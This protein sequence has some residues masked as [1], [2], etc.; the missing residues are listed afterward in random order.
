M[1]LATAMTTVDETTEAPCR[2]RA[3]TL[4][5]LLA[6]PDIL[7]PPIAVIPYLAWPS[8]L[9]MIVGR[10]KCGKSTMVGQAVAA[11][12]VGGEFL[13]AHMDPSR[14]LWLA[15]DEPVQDLVQRLNRFGADPDNVLVVEGDVGM[16][17][18]ERVCEDFRPAAIIV[19]CLANLAA[20]T[21]GDPGNAMEWGNI[22][23]PLR[24][25]ARRFNASFILIHH[26]RKA[27]DEF[28]DSTA[29]GAQ[30][31]MI[32][33]VL[34]SK[35]GETRREI[36]VKGRVS[37]RHY[38]VDFRQD[39]YEL[40]SD[41]PAEP[42]TTGDDLRIQVLEVLAGAEPEGLPTTQWLKASGVSPSAFY[43]MRGPFTEQKLIRVEP[44]GNT[45]INHLT[46]AGKEFVAL[47]A[48]AQAE[49]V[50]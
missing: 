43:R 48:P 9:S 32:L 20:G 1:A 40:V 27:S 31:D 36:R 11:L 8:R 28:R 29:I 35:D 3:R 42:I 7:K 33:T 18:L 23:L 34:Q 44:K 16:E 10:E 50:I 38:S 6:D 24:D 49:L 19:D 21:V 22:F 17:D 39:R 15:L 12:S 2:F 46:S 5:E 14:V 4:R 45:K 47:R 26:S 41:G 25:L 37:Q 30:V 13:G